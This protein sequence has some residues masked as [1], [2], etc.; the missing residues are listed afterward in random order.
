[1]LKILKTDLVKWGL[2]F[3]SDIFYPYQRLLFHKSFIFSLEINFLLSNLKPTS[4]ESP[5]SSHYLGG[6]RGST[7]LHRSVWMQK[8]VDGDLDICVTM[9][10][11]VFLR[12]WQTVHGPSLERQ[13]W[14]PHILEQ[15]ITGSKIM[16]AFP[17]VSSERRW[18]FVWTWPCPFTK[19]V[20]HGRWH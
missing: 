11:I 7:V 2:N 10:G 9:P 8:K 6:L 3:I 15:T 1:M 16:A 14:Q 19:P 13:R 18:R 20:G 4:S 12:P 5:A 17:A